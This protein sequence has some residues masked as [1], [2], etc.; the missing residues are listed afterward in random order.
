MNDTFY[1]LMANLGSE[2]ARL[3]RARDEHNTERLLGA[4]E[5]SCQ[6]LKEVQMLQSEKENVR[7]LSLL[8]DVL[9]DAVRAHPQ[10]SVRVESLREYFMPFALRVL[11]P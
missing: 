9:D 2:V 5:R 1:F 6:I 4:Y 7:E 10:F 8:Q 3:F 11:N